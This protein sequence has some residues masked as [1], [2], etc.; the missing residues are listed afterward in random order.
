MPKIK[1]GSGRGHQWRMHPYWVRR[2]PSSAREFGT[3]ESMAAIQ[4]NTRKD[5]WIVDEGDGEATRTHPYTGKATTYGWRC[6]PKL[7][8]YYSGWHD[9]D[10]YVV[11]PFVYGAAKFVGSYKSGQA[12][13]PDG[14]INAW[15]ATVPNGIYLVTH[16]GS[17]GC[18]FENVMA[19]GTKTNRVGNP[20]V[21]TRTT[22]VEVTDGKFTLSGSSTRYGTISWLK[23]D[24]I[25]EAV[26]PRAWLPSPK[27]EWWQMK[28]EDDEPK[29]GLVRIMVPHQKAPPSDDCRK[30]WLYTPAKCYRFVTNTNKRGFHEH[31][32]LYPDFPGFTV[33]FL[34]WL[35]DRHDTDGDGFLTK[36]EVEVEQDKD[37]LSG[38]YAFWTRPWGA[39]NK[40]D[41]PGF[42]VIN[43]GHLM[44][45][46]DIEDRDRSSGCCGRDGVL[47]RS[48]FVHGRL[49]QAEN[50]PCDLFESTEHTHRYHDGL[51]CGS[52]KGGVPVNW[53]YHN[54]DGQHGFSVLISDVPCTDKDGCPSVDD[55]DANVTLCDTLLDNRG[56]LKV[57]QFGTSTTTFGPVTIDC[58]GAT[59]KYVQVVLPGDK[60]RLVPTLEVDVHRASH[61]NVKNGRTQ[62]YKSTD[63]E[64]PTVCYS[65]VMP[66]PPAPDAPDLLAAAKKFPKTVVDDNPEDPIFWS[67]CYERVKVTEWL[68]LIGGVEKVVA[69]KPAYSFAG[70]KK[71]ETHCLDCNSLRQNTHG[72]YDFHHF[73][74]PRW[75]LQPKGQCAKCDASFNYTST[76]LSWKTKAPVTKCPRSHPWAY[77]PNQNFDYCCTS[78]NDRYG[79]NGIHAGPLATRGKS[80]YRGEFVACPAPPCKDFSAGY[81]LGERGALVCPNG[82]PTAH[83]HE[84]ALASKALHPTGGPGVSFRIPTRGFH[85]APEGCIVKTV[86]NHNNGE[87]IFNIYLGGVNRNEWTLI[88]HKAYDDP[89][90][91]QVRPT[92]ALHRVEAC[93]Q[94]AQETNG[95]NL[96]NA[97][98]YQRDDVLV[99]AGTAR[100]GLGMV[101]APL[102][103]V[104]C[105][106][107]LPAGNK[108]E[109]P[110]YA[111][112]RNPGTGS[113][114]AAVPATVTLHAI[115]SCNQ[116]TWESVGDANDF[117]TAMAP[118]DTLRVQ[119]V[120]TAGAGDDGV[121]LVVDFSDGAGNVLLQWK[122]EM[123]QR[124]ITRNSKYGGTWLTST[125]TESMPLT[126]GKPFRLLFE[127]W[128]SSTVAWHLAPP[129]AHTCDTGLVASQAQC[130]AANKEL[131][132]SA[133]RVPGKAMQTGSGG[134]CLDGGWGQVPLGCSSQSSWTAHYK[135]SGDT[136]AG[137]IHSAYVAA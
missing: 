37:A 58:K 117:T 101:G 62:A 66:L 98:Q 104:G 99:A 130:E 23:L 22:S 39:H 32:A 27:K 47:S 123:A 88:C 82:M 133:G 63:P 90:T 109:P 46:I 44:T 16:S 108:T 55:K 54:D 9:L 121:D 122:H 72:E 65:V 87:T 96:C 97:T 14:R 4:E 125:S 86:N 94:C 107:L 68:P 111:M 119:G 8:Y 28:F 36:K 120:A 15:E 45:D 128:M 69:V 75:W 74:T 57:D 40:K 34:E 127:R 102:A 19:E 52:R 73:E 103:D 64:L 92:V 124:S 10:S 59:G 26:F 33:P 118:G 91:A 126:A 134:R 132:A 60:N 29:I 115:D 100:G 25:S 53:G 89:W 83:P 42:N 24:L 67:T 77:N 43:V 7:A 114:Y 35:F 84:C 11:P 76:A 41:R 30:W 106:V 136:G 70:S 3:E 85:T 71:G 95:A 1:K 81:R 61:P 78:P 48:E 2:T 56:V 20:Y 80:C 105:Q 5:G 50:R 110:P 131:A 12:R 21:E 31:L 51:T 13:C 17:K 112:W 18:S 79:Q 129:G 137:C 116:C 135:T 113:M 38:D 93:D 49:N 6:E